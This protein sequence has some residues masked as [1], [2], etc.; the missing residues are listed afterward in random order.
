MA[1]FVQNCLNALSHVPA[2]KLLIILMFLAMVCA[3]IAVLCVF[4]AYPMSLLQVAV[5][6]IF[7]DDKIMK[8]GLLATAV[9]GF[10]GV[11]RLNPDALYQPLI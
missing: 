10:A 8:A 9:L 4:G 3:H 2:E 5:W 1:A 7:T 6:L 11:F